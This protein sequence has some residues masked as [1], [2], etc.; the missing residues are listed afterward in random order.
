MMALPTLS[1]AVGSFLARIPRFAPLARPGTLQGSRTIDQASCEGALPVSLEIG[2]LRESA[3]RIGVLP[4]EGVGW[5]GKLVRERLR[6]SLAERAAAAPARLPPGGDVDAAA[7]RCIAS[8]A[9]R[10][11]I[12]GGLSA[13]GAHVGEAV[14][15]ATEGVA[16][17]LCVPAVA[18][19][20][21]SKV[22]LSA[23][24]QIDLVFDLAAIH[25]V[26][27]D[28]GDTAELAAIFEI[29]LHAER[30]SGAGPSDAATRP[31]TEDEILARLGLGLLQNA[32]LGLLPFV[33]IPIAAVGG[34][35]A[36][37]RVGDEAR[38]ALR[39][40]VALREALRGMPSCTPAELL[41]EGAWL[42]ATADGVATHD[43]LLIVAAVARTVSGDPGHARRRLD[44][45]DERRWLEQAAALD[46][47]ERAA[48][49]D[50]LV[51]VAG[52]RGP[53]RHPHRR[54]LAHVGAALGRAVDL[55]RV[56]AIHQQLSAGPAA[57]DGA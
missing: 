53:T 17:P 29:A 3:R 12:A 6:R 36:T 54:F 44:S 39:R 47:G 30:A 5:F 25:G 34:Y 40:R 14:T 8:A 27:F 43:E 19:S 41:L 37:L 33:G 56:D 11:A 38:R 10:A 16:A 20:I 15:L 2:D 57:A 49:L 45:A 46:A 9:R 55:T 31:S 1:H 13:V 7:E 26:A 35:R 23:K 51:L 24:V 18:A 28:V 50:A 21:M 22:V 32:M 4:P 48:L 52:L 42:L